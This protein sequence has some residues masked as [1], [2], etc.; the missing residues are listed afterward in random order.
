MDVL[1]GAT[2]IPQE[3]QEKAYS[4]ENVKRRK[5][6]ICKAVRIWEENGT[7]RRLLTFHTAS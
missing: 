5:R 1:Q 3:E 7:K 6:V 4:Q 2:R